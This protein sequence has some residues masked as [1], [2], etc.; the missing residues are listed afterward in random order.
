MTEMP[1]NPSCCPLDEPGLSLPPPQQP[2][3][4]V[5]PQPEVEGQPEAGHGEA[6]HGDPEAA[7]RQLGRRAEQTTLS[8]QKELLVVHI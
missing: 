2:Q 5:L 1:W 3:L 8:K 6:C 7:L 4:S